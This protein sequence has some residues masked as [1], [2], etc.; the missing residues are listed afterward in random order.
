MRKPFLLL[1]F[2]LFVLVS[3]ALAGEQVIDVGFDEIKGTDTAAEK[4]LKSIVRVRDIGEQY[5]TGGVYLITYYGNLDD[6]FRKEN[7]KLISNPI[8]DQTWRFCSIFSTK[9]E[10]GVVVGRNW[11]NQNV[12]SIIVSRYKP[13]GG[14]AS[15]SF[16]RAIDMGFPLNVKLDEM[17]KSPYGK[18]LLLAPFYAYDGMN[19]H[20]LCAMVTGIKSVKVS[21]KDGKELLFI[22]NIV[23]NLLDNTKTVDEAAA[24]VEKYVP[25][26]ISPTEINC[27][28]LVSDSSGKSVI[29]EYQDD[30]WRKIYPYKSWQVMT[31]KV[32][33][34]TDDSE[35]RERCWRYKSISESLE[36]SNGNI[37]WKQG[38]NILKDVSQGGTTWSVI[39]LPVQN[40]LYLT[41]YQNWDRIYHIKS[42]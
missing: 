15:V 37:D 23:R 9:T 6:L 39:Y 28:F 29:L 3:P 12:G 14:Y 22:G 38:M 33:Y 30:K 31:N 7:K 10:N 42:F 36:K 16:S 20:G 18:K 2:L 25:F 35:L 32:I 26:D 1:V 21:A 27:H 19:E 5:A 8:I 11:D 24:L 13:E 34:N 17:A 4:T 40:E 41:V